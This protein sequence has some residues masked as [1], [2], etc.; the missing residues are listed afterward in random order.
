MQS[1]TVSVI[2]RF[3]GVLQG[4]ATQARG[5]IAILANGP[6]RW[7]STQFTPE[8]LRALSQSDLNSYNTRAQQ[9]RADIRLDQSGN[10][11]SRPRGK[12][13]RRVHH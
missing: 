7:E 3:I 8:G 12:D 9:N 5:P 6:V 4:I 13:G 10:G 1:Q 11:H 2:T